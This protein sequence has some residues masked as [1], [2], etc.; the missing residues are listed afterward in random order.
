[1][2]NETYTPYARNKRNDD[3]GTG[4]ICRA[5]KYNAEVPLSRD[6]IDS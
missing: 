1:V 2:A 4:C 5:S 6:C 3:A